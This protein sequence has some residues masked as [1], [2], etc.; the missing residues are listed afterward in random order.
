MPRKVSNDVD[1]VEEI[2][3]VNEINEVKVK[4]KRA[5]RKKK[6]PVNDTEHPI[7]VR[8]PLQYIEIPSEMIPELFNGITDY[9]VKISC[10][11]WDLTFDINLKRKEN[12]L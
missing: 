3:E 8:L 6:E 11:E 9:K 1:E 5:P 2:E 7:E 4:P 10:F 12:I